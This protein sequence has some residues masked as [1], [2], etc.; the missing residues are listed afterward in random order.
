MQILSNELTCELNPSPKKKENRWTAAL[1]ADVQEKR[2]SVA[3][4][5]EKQ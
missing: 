5:G 1:S 2:H 4:L 3:G